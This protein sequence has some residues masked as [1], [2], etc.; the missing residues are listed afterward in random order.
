MRA[1][2]TRGP[3]A[4]GRIVHSWV[5]G[6]GDEL[7]HTGP[8]DRPGADPYEEAI[9]DEIG[10]L[11]KRGVFAVSVNENVGVD[12]DHPPW[13]SYAND[14]IVSQLPALT[15]GCKPLPATV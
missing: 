10:L 3:T 11:V 9:E 15:P 2:C 1:S 8:G 5:R 12:G 6:D 13:P 7:M 14:R 4:G